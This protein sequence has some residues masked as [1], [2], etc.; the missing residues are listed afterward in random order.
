MLVVH[1]G[2][3]MWG[4]VKRGGLRGQSSWLRRLLRGPSISPKGH[5]QCMQHVHCGVARANQHSARQ[6]LPVYFYHQLGHL[7]WKK[8]GGEGECAAPWQHRAAA[9]CGASRPHG[10][11]WLDMEGLVAGRPAGGVHLRPTRSGQQGGHLGSDVLADLLHLLVLLWAVGAKGRWQQLGQP[12]RVAGLARWLGPSPPCHH[13]ITT[14][15]IGCPHCPC[16]LLH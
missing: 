11:S 10:S 15:C 7:A 16:D 4:R 13:E 9:P 2:G 5:Q 1:S 8:G 12:Q 3:K 6:V 14:R